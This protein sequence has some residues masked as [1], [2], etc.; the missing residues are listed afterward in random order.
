MFPTATS[1]NT[2]H[3]GKCFEFGHFLSGQLNLGGLGSLDDVT[4]FRGSDDGQRSLRFSPAFIAASNTGFRFSTSV[5]LPN[6]ASPPNAPVPQAQVPNAIFAITSIFKFFNLLLFLGAKVR[7]FC[8]QPPNQFTDD[9]TKFTDSIIF[10][11]FSR[12]F[13]ISLHTI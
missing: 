6:T 7:R 2:C 1:V 13:F 10:V 12:F 5:L 3:I 9:F 11:S 8:R 4:L